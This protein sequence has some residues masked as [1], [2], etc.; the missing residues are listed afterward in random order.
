MRG[1]FQGLIANDKLVSFGFYHCLFGAP[2]LPYPTTND[3]WIQHLIQP[4]HLN[5]CPLHSMSTTVTHYTKLYPKHGDLTSSPDQAYNLLPAKYFDHILGGI[6][7][8]TIATLGTVAAPV[9]TTCPTFMLHKFIPISA[10][11]S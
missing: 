2:N 1:I 10:E 3:I 8:G 5:I 9:P 4:H 6:G 7:A 11:T